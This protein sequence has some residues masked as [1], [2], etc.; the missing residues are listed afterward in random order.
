MATAEEQRIHAYLSHLDAD[1]KA[2]L[3]E[4]IGG[5]FEEESSLAE[6][7]RLRFLF[8]WQ[9][10]HHRNADLR[11]K[12]ASELPSFSLA[13]LT[14]HPQHDQLIELGLRLVGSSSPAVSRTA[15]LSLGEISAGLDEATR[16]RILQKS[17]RAF[18]LGDAHKKKE[19]ASAI[20]KVLDQWFNAG[21]TLS[22]GDQERVFTFYKNAAEQS[23]ALNNANII[24]RATKNVG[25]LILISDDF[26]A[27]Y[28]D[29]FAEALDI[30]VLSFIDMSNIPSKGIDIFAESIADQSRFIALA[31]STMRVEDPEYFQDGL[32]VFGHIVQSLSNHPSP[33]VQDALA[34]NLD[35]IE[36]ILPELTPVVRSIRS[37]FA[38]RKDGDL[39]LSLANGSRVLD[40]LKSGR[41]GELLS[42]ALYR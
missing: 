6:Q 10:G 19:T 23:A 2:N 36:E 18:T 38:E 29:S 12:V 4:G 14:D 26:L 33:D 37:S 39:N 13:R 5:P 30:D 9:I 11:R 8:A 34:E 35:A 7:E 27:D 24:I 22:K 28:L 17:I 42:E 3:V 15:I 16:S 1:E 40:T 21:I 25:S 32:D 31:V 20:S 41:T